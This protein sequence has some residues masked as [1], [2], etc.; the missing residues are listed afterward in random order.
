MEHTLSE[1]IKS[2]IGSSDPE[3][4]AR[5][6]DLVT[7]MNQ[8]MQNMKDA[9]G[10]ENGEDQTEIDG[11]NDAVAQC[12]TDM[13]LAFTG[14]TGVDFHNYETETEREEHRLCRVQQDLDW[15]DRETQRTNAQTE[16][17]DAVNAIP[18]CLVN[19]ADNMYM[20]SVCMQSASTWYDDHKSDLDSQIGVFNTAA[21]T[22]DNKTTECNQAQDDFEADFCL[23]SSALTSACS[24]HTTCYNETTE[25]RGTLVSSAGNKETSQK[26]LWLSICRIECLIGLFTDAA[27]ADLDLNS[28]QACNEAA[29]C[30]TSSL[31]LNYPAADAKE[32]C[33]TATATWNTSEYTSMTVS[34]NSA[35][36]GK[37]ETAIQTLNV[38]ID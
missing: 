30:D 20:L 3:V 36:D 29:A 9:I 11:A 2:A 12:N 35:Y 14:A 21:E 37:T 32:P 22:F 24:I 38:C 4:M 13:Q 8:Q 31:N 28:V 19:F 15:N 7:V 33:D 23:Y 25:T 26:E 17:D 5:V 34:Y 10:A 16:S 27:S 1:A 6:T 18:S